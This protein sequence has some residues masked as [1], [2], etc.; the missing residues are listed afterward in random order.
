MFVF[1]SPESKSYITN[2]IFNFLWV[3]VLYELNNMNNIENI[4]N[5]CK[6]VI[7]IVIYFS[8]DNISLKIDNIYA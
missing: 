2:K 8:I 7:I 5:V 3:Q 6:K 4:K 1:W